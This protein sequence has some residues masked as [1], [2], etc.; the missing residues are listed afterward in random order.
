MDDVMFTFQERLCAT[1][2]V[3]IE[4]EN[5]TSEQVFPT[6]LN[7]FLEE[8]P[9]KPICPKKKRDPKP[10][11][12]PKKTSPALAVQPEPVSVPSEETPPS[13]FTFPPD[14][15][16]EFNVTLNDLQFAFASVPK[17]SSA[18]SESDLSSRTLA[19]VLVRAHSS[20]D[21]D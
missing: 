3:E 20:D 5:G 6:R 14:V 13:S 16:L 4:F 7:E 1:I 9:P 11:L 8:L 2:E 12:I 15:E 21:S 19:T 10:R 18:V 17:E